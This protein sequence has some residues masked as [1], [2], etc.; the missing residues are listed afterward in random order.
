MTDQYTTGNADSGSA[1]TQPSLSISAFSVLG[2][3]MHAMTKDDLLDVVVCAV[4]QRTQCVIAN[5]NLHSL[6][7][8]SKSR[9]MREL[10]SIAQYTQIDGMPLVWI[11]RLLG[12]RLTRD[13]RTTNLD[14]IPLL[15]AAAAQRQL[16]LFFLGSR[17]G[18]A[19][20]GAQLITKEYPGLQIATRHG[21]FDIT[22]DGS[23]NQDVLAEIRNYAPDILMLGMGMP[24][25]EIWLVDNLKDLHAHAILCCGGLMD[26]VA[27]EIPVPPRWLGPLGLEWLY[28]LLSAPRAVWRRYLLEPWMILFRLCRHYVRSG[29]FVLP[30]LD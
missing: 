15:F 22:A 23:D 8:W 21:Y 28:R 4:S 3:H 12:A 30:E 2:L 5:H 16:K 19:S 9:K 25:Q 29:Q 11:G 17:P 20:R 10:Y 7:H 6:Y 27:H 1:S 14:F 26:L 24:R 18:V 13:H